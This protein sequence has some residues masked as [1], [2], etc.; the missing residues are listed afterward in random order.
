VSGDD[1]SVTL[2]Y[3][4]PASDYAVVQHERLDYKHSVGG[5][6]Y[7][8]RPLLEAASGMGERIAKKIREAFS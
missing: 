8:E 7:L 4:G 6:K 3:G 5:P 1:V 2:S